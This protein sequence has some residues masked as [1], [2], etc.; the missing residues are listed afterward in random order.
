MSLEKVKFDFEVGF[1]VRKIRG[2]SSSW[3]AC[4]L[5]LEDIAIVWHRCS[6]WED[7]ERFDTGRSEQLLD[8]ALCY[9]L[10]AKPRSSV[11]CNYIPLNYSELSLNLGRDLPEYGNS[12]MPD[13][14]QPNARLLHSQ[15]Y[16][17]WSG[18]AH[19]SDH[20]IRELHCELG[21]GYRSWTVSNDIQA[22]E[23]WSARSWNAV[24]ETAWTA[25]R[26]C[27]FLHRS[28]VHFGWP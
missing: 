25:L 1:Y 9:V 28:E 13:H 24:D 20:L 2:I 7:C 18:F 3:S 8:F 21:K 12:S 11:K 15:D 14:Q 27:C 19:I 6:D 5:W 17:G 23:R 26:Q 16:F 10:I 4:W 22:P